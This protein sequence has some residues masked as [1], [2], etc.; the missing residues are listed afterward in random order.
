[1]KVRD[2]M[3]QPFVIE[4]DMAIKDVAKIMSSKNI[5]SLIFLS[6]GYVKG[7]ITDSDLVRNFSSSGKVKSI[8]STDVV[9]IGSNENLD[10][11]AQKMKKHNIKRLP[12]VDDDKLVGII[13]VTELIANSDEIDE[14]FFFD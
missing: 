14:D 12:V 5:E 8:M 4:K 11:A 9:T 1:M 2:V 7:I 13:T 6:G 3:K 10:N